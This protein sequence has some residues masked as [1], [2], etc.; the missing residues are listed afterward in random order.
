MRSSTPFDSPEADD[1]RSTESSAA[2]TGE[3]LL[4]RTKTG[5]PSDSYTLFYLFVLVESSWR[6]PEMASWE[7]ACN[8]VEVPLYVPGFGN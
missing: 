8:R 6:I 3:P 5:L 7:L 4:E 1:F 2:G